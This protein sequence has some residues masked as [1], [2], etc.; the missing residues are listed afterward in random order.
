M[1]EHQKPKVLCCS[2]GRGCCSTILSYLFALPVTSSWN[3]FGEQQEAHVWAGTN[4]AIA[5]SLA[6]GCL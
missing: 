4:E 5:P 1:E 2:R 3:T 6:L